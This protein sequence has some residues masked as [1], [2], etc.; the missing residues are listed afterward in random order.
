MNEK[1]IIH[2][3]IEWRICSPSKGPINL[4]KWCYSI[5]YWVTIRACS[6]WACV[7]VYGN[8]ERN[9]P[10]LLPIHI[11]SSYP[12]FFTAA[13]GKI[14]RICPIQWISSNTFPLL[15]STSPGG[16]RSSIEQSRW[17]E[18]SPKQLEKSF[19]S[20]WISPSSV[21]PFSIVFRVRPVS[22]SFKEWAFPPF[23]REY[24]VYSVHRFV[25]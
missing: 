15:L 9:R 8:L 16:A 25:R 14:E 11:L 20:V 22:S 21:H 24:S 23:Q 1:I 18:N 2:P 3:S 7:F 6:Y 5:C 4:L 10:D 19:S 12:I 17:E 13:A